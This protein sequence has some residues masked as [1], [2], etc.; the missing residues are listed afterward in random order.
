MPSLVK[1]V[2][3]STAAPASKDHG[4]AAIKQMVDFALGRLVNALTSEPEVDLVVSIMQSMISCLSDARELHPTLELNEAQLRELVHGLLVVLGDS[5]Q[6]RAM[7]RGGAGSDDMDAGE[8]EEDEDDDASQS[9]ENQVAEQELQ[10][11]LA[12]CIGTL[13]KTH[14]AA[15][16]PVFMTLLWDKVAALAAP[17]CLIEDRRLALFVVDDVLEHCG[18]PAMRQLDVFLP[19]LENALREVTEP[20]LVQAAAFGVGVCASQ[21]GDAFAP[22]AEQ[23]LQLL[24]SVVAHPRA[25]SSPE[26]RNATDNAVAALGKFCE[27]QGGAVDAA[28]LFPQWLELLPL[29]G[30]L[31]ESLAVSRRLCRYVND[32]HPLVLGAP[33]YQHLGKVVAVLAAVAEEKFLRKMSKAVGTKEASALRQELSSTLAGLRA[34]VPEPVMG[35]AWASLPA[36]QQAALHALFA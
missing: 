35:Q 29:R 9:S 12:E 21:G 19:I 23:C 11:V 33:D 32:R 22:H 17:G 14:G 28:T 25:H 26:Q 7:R 8:A 20:G 3:I 1:C 24:H 31:E 18:G 16:F 10:F 34:T 2:A 30:D 4:E 6:R 13:A 15:F 36:P 27:F 5:F